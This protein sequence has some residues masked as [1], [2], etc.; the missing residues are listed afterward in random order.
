LD[1]EGY[2]EE[3]EVWGEKYN[4]ASGMDGPF[5]RVGLPSDGKQRIMDLLMNKVP[6][7]WISGASTGWSNLDDLYRVV[8]GE[9]TVITGTPGSGK[10]EWL[11]AMLVNMAEE[12]DW[13][14]GLCCFEAP[15][16]VLLIQLL[17]KRHR[18]HESELAELHR[19]GILDLDWLY[20]HFHAI[21]GSFVTLTPQDLI[22]RARF[23]V[24]KQGINAI[25]IDPY[26]YIDWP[27]DFMNETQ[28]VSDLLTALQQFGKETMC[29]IFLIAH[30][31]K[32]NAW[33]NKLP[34]LYDIA[35]SANFFNKCDMGIVI[36]RERK[37]SPDVDLRELKIQV[38]KVRNRD[39]GQLGTTSLYYHWRTRRYNTTPVDNWST[40]EA[41]MTSDNGII[42]KLDFGATQE[43]Y[44]QD[45]LDG[46]AASQG[47]GGDEDEK[48]YSGAP[49]DH[50]PDTDAGAQ[51]EDIDE[52][53][54]LDFG[55]NQDSYVPKPGRTSPRV[56]RRKD[57]DEDKEL[58]FDFDFSD[59]KRM[60]R[61]PLP[62]LSEKRR[63]LIYSLL[64]RDWDQDTVGGMDYD[65]LTEF[66]SAGEE[67]KEEEEEQEEETSE[68]EFAAE[69]V[70][71]VEEYV[72]GAEE[73]S[74]LV[75][76]SKR[77][78]GAAEE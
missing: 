52:E 32:S 57:G 8:P 64:E 27:A 49:K 35:G 62:P 60:G 10:T 55:A 14:F 34:T 19:N 12:K 73:D 42:Q 58:E 75:T 74:P 24:E 21:G 48:L 56:P 38:C 3:G 15:L 77:D 25:L 16:D 5:G 43:F 65:A 69:G 66:Y 2:Q 7:E 50:P 36:H 4:E 53:T 39:A 33:T 9:L 45:Q 26:N 78:E 22:T 28:F 37:L 54:E 68:G 67:P 70:D 18:V 1:R 20:A 13:R 11:L 59:Q 71:D 31:T 51:D 17:E 44:A 30:P 23:L 72:V 46:V 41:P 76:E 29:H 40:S 63:P 47:K 61:W 6:Q